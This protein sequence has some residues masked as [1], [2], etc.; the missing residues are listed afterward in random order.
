[1]RDLAKEINNKQLEI[2]K[3]RKLEEQSP[4]LQ[5]SSPIR[6]RTLESIESQEFNIEP[7]PVELANLSGTKDEENKQINKDQPVN[8]QIQNKSG[9]DKSNLNPAIE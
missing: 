1:M 6:R 8:G 7:K 2:E 3:E 4:I 9:L 5:S